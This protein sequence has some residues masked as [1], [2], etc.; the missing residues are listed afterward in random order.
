MAN[1]YADPSLVAQRSGVSYG[2]LG[3]ANQGALDA[4]VSSLNNRA[5]AAIEDYTKRDFLPHTSVTE[6]YDGTGDAFLD[7]RGW[8]VTSITSVTDT[9]TVLV[10]GTDYRQVPARSPGGEAPGILE[11]CKDVWCKDWGRYVVVYSYGYTTPPLDV[12]R[13]AEDLIIRVLQVAKVDRQATGTSS[14][15]MDGFSA[16]YARGADLATQL[17]GDDMMALARWRYRR[18]A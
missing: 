16:T 18:L 7:L 13:V 1:Q 17:T 6:S 5:S 3:L 10:D 11:R 15:S 8:P 14:V 12:K 4:L 2:D 9:G